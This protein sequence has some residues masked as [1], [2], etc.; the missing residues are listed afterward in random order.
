MLAQQPTSALSLMD[1]RFRRL[2]PSWLSTQQPSLSPSNVFP[3]SDPQ[4]TVS[5]GSKV[6]KR[7]VASVPGHQLSWSEAPCVTET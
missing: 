1:S 4:R 5:A 3:E 6:S 2:L 7:L